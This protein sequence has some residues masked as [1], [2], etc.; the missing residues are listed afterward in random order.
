MLRDWRDLPRRWLKTEYGL[1]VGLAVAFLAALIVWRFAPQARLIGLALAGAV[2][3]AALVQWPI[4]GAFYVSFSTF[5]RLASLFPGIDT[6]IVILTLSAYAARKLLSWEPTW[7]FPPALRWAGLW[8]AWMVASIVWAEDSAVALYTLTLYLKSFLVFVLILEAARDHRRIVHLTSAAVAGAVFAVAVSAVTGYRFFF[9][10]AAAEL[11]RVVAVEKT[12]LYGLWFDPNYF[13]LALLA[14]MGLTFA[15]WRTR[16]SGAVRAIAA[17]GFAAVVAGIVFSLSR[18]A[19]LSAC[20]GLVACLWYEH[21]RLRI[22][23]VVGS[24]VGLVLIFFPVDLAERV[25]SLTSRQADASLRNRERQLLGAVEMAVDAFPFG[26]GL[27]NYYYH[28]PYYT[29]MSRPTLSHNSYAD[30]A[31]EGGVM[32]LLFFGGFVVTLFQ[33]TRSRNRRIVPVDFTDNL[34]IGLRISLIAFLLGATF[35]SAAA[36]VPLWWLAGLVAAKESHDREL[37]EQEMGALAPVR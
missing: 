32:S 30:L 29:S 23:L 22:L 12:R 18:A 14:L 5:G 26:V 4:L 37:A 36:F 7:R 33:A 19:M 16:L 34:A 21:R 24:V 1:A 3:A 31:A 17:V 15:L 8:L 10:G 13:A 20:M 25:E 28:S 11:S 27:G 6:A 9:T 2:G 35:L